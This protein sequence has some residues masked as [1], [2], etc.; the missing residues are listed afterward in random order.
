MAT[1]RT[2]GI[3]RSSSWRRSADTPDPQAPPQNEFDAYLTGAYVR[4][5]VCNRQP[6]PG[7]AWINVV[8]HGELDDLRDLASALNDRSLAAVKLDMWQQVAAFLAKDVLTAAG[9]DDLLRDL[10]QRVLVPLELR[11][12]DEWWTP[13]RPIDL[14]RTVLAALQ[15]SRRR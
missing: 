14:A 5:L 7:W 8:A 13:L 10:Q 12:A 2:K 4:W 3:E 1:T 11:L 15:D 9:D 6:V